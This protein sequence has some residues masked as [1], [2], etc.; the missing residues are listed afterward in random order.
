MQQ[1]NCGQEANIQVEL[2]KYSMDIYTEDLEKGPVV[3][4]CKG[5]NENLGSNTRQEISDEAN[6]YQ[7]GKTSAPWSWYL[8][9]VM[10]IKSNV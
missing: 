6:M 10:M 9:K 7:I 5:D 3:G 4:S 8:L 2:K 1:L